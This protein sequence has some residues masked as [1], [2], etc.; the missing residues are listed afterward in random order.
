MF[1]NEAL[2]YCRE[3]NVRTKNIIF[4]SVFLEEISLIIDMVGWIVDC[5][6]STFPLSNTIFMETSP[7]EVKG[8]KIQAFTRFL[9][10]SAGRYHYHLFA[11]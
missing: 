5:I 3:I 8:C 7:L 6:H 1:C 11:L 9:C 10:P 4:H 2:Y